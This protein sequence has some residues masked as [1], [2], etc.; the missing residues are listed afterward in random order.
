MKL[1]I[2]EFNIY[3]EEL[4]LVVVLLSVF[5]TG[6]REYFSNYFMCYL[7]IAFHEFS[8]MFIASLF[9]IKTTRLN[10]RI[11]GLSINLNNINRQGLKWICIFLAGPISNVILAIMFYNIPIV[12]T[13]NLV[14]AII[15]LMPIYPLDGYNILKLLLEIIKCKNIKIQMVI[16]NTVM[17]GLIILGVCQACFLHNPSIILMFFYI[18]IQSSSLRKHWDLGIYQKYYKNITK[19]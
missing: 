2:K 19:F 5:F 18:F 16:E 4:V 11:S 17:I 12:Y 10:I 9:D 15:N 6:I 8:H 7:F 14:L 13:I 1:K 3:V